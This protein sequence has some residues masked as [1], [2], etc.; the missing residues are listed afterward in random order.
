M[1]Y[2]ARR[3]AVNLPRA[4]AVVKP[5]CALIQE[6]EDTSARSRHT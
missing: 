5:V 2:A 6:M 4:G 1:K 3:F